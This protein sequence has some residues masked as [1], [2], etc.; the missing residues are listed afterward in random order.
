MSTQT[1][2][3]Q[4]PNKKRRIGDRVESLN[5]HRRAV[6]RV[7][8]KL[9]KGT[10]ETYKDVSSF[11]ADFILNFDT[12]DKETARASYLQFQQ[13]IEQYTSL[14]EWREQARG[15]TST[16]SAKVIGLENV[17]EWDHHPIWILCTPRTERTVET[18]GRTL[19][20]SAGEFLTWG[21]PDIKTFD[22]R[23]FKKYRL[24]FVIEKIKGGTHV[25][26]RIKNVYMCLAKAKK[27][28]A[29]LYLVTWKHFMETVLSGNV[30]KPP[31]WCKRKE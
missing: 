21:L 20:C 10:C 2:T 12:I 26:H 30:V 27:T 15:P 18:S 19:N 1:I 11:C 17:K 23:V 7:F 3:T 25:Q 22:R 16:R 24:V 8:R 29:S 13:E 4:P 31:F 9:I 6:E 14:L 28:D 5:K